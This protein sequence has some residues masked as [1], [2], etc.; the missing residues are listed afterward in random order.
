MG[1]QAE[2]ERIMLLPKS[3]GKGPRNSSSG[4]LKAL[5]SKVTG[6]AA[7]AGVLRVLAAVGVSCGWMLVSSLLILIN[8]HILKDLKFGWVPALCLWEPSWQLTLQPTASIRHIKPAAVDGVFVADVP[9][10]IQ[11]DMRIVNQQQQ[12]AAGPWDCRQAS[13][14]AM[15]AAHHSA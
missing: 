12:G 13:R 6:T 8:K 11:P 15:L 7:S 10:M 4:S 5:V 14:A 9:C 2:A 3:I 1:A